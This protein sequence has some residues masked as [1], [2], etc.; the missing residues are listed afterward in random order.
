MLGWST[1][2]IFAAIS[3]ACERQSGLRDPRTDRV[4]PPRPISWILDP[5][6]YAASWRISSPETEA[7]KEGRPQAVA[8]V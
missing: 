4:P 5:T 3:R 7:V 8:D 1:A 2:L 6:S